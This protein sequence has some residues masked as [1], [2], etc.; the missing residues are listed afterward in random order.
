MG[1]HRA[2]ANSALYYSTFEVKPGSTETVTMPI[3]ENVEAVVRLSEP[4]P[5]GATVP[6]Y[7]SP[8]PDRAYSET[9]YP[10][11]EYR[12]LA[13]YK[14]WGVFHYFFAYRDLM[15]EDWDD[16]F[17][18][19]LPKFIAAKDAREYNLTVAD[20]ITHVDDSCATVQSRAL[21]EYFGEAPAGLRVRLIEKKPVITQI[22]DEDAKKAGVQV[23][24][25]VSTVDGENI[26]ERVKRE[27]QYLASSTQQSLSD[28]V[29]QRILNGPQKV[30]LRH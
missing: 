24:D 14:I 12:I 20:M 9:P 18:T 15:D 3:G 30:Q 6:A 21:E 1:F 22:L 4:V 7:P 25:I 23:G 10:S 26:V 19:F 17:N 28:Q 5:A 16:V 13:A 2:G 29:T 11:T 27:A 8:Q